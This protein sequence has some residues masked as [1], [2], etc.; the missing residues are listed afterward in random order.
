MRKALVIGSEGNVGAS[1]KCCSWPV[2][3][4]DEHRFAVALQVIDP[5]EGGTARGDFAG[6]WPSPVRPL[7]EWSLHQGEVTL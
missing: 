7:L 3:R 5:G 6:P 2:R 1:T 4:R